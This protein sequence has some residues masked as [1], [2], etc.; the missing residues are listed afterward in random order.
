MFAGKRNKVT[1]FDAQP[2][3]SS[4]LKNANVIS[5]DENDDLYAFDKQVRFVVSTKAFHNL[6]VQSL[7]M[8]LITERLGQQEADNPRWDTCEHP[9]EWV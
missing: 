1:S 9:Q 6:F 5:Q 4:P 7:V 3:I 2:N 8:V